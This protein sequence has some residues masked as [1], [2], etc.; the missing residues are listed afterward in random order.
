M[1][2]LPKS[3]QEI[4]DVIG[5]ED[6]LY[7]IGQ[8]PRCPTPSRRGSEVLLYV[9]TL[10]R[11]TPDH[12]LVKILGY[13]LARKLSANCA[14]LWKPANCNGIVRS[15]RN[16]SMA[17]FWESGHTI[18]DIAA[19]FE[20]TPKYTKKILQDMGYNTDHNTRQVLQNAD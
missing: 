4:A 14:G 3:V 6:A 8:L 9:P 18:Q 1:V 5:R 19:I 11:L 10:N 2:R 7:L 16:K 17:E 15:F 13:P 20:T 12:R